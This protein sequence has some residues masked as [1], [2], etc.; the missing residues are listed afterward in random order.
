MWQ[1]V[2]GGQG[3]REYLPLRELEGAEVSV[4]AAPLE[5]ALVTTIATLRARRPIGALRRRDVDALRPL[6]DYRT[7]AWPSCLTRRDE[8][9]DFAA[10]VATGVRQGRLHAGVWAPVL[11]A[12]ERWLHSYG[13]AMERAWTELEPRWRRAAHLLD[14]EAERIE[15]AADRG[16]ALALAGSAAGSVRG[17]EWRLFERPEPAGLRLNRGRLVLRP[18]LAPAGLVEAG[19][20]LLSVG[21][22]LTPR[23]DDAPPATLEALIA[24]SRAA[25]LRALD[26]PVSAGGLAERHGFSPSG[27]THHLGALEQAGLI[28]RERAGR[29]VVVRRTSRGTRLLALYE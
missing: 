10:D 27:I 7:R 13:A 18:L 17:G 19:D 11:D 3:E 15:A 25:I 22:P 28:A 23:H 26:R 5:S 9:R 12:P 16:G 8:Q 1:H 29:R 21:Y 4:A 2:A 24:P 6:I 14:R 20:E